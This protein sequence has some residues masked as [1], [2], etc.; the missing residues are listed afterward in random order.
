MPLQ[1]LT[2]LAG[3]G[4]GAEVLLAAVL[5]AA[6]PISIVDAGGVVRFAN[7]A[8]VAALGDGIVGRRREDRKSV[9]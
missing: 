3:L 7:P 2:H 4:V 9:V 5:E 1:P 6:Q 8:A